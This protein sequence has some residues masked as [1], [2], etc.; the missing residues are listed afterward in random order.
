MKRRCPLSKRLWWLTLL[1]CVSLLACAGNSSDGS[2]PASVA[3]SADVLAVKPGAPKLVKAFP[4]LKFENPTDLQAP[5]DGTN[6]LFVLEQEG[7]IRVFPNDA[8][9]KEAK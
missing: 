1:S 8:N 5:P 3:P 6:R 2:T 7:V 9:V 4:N